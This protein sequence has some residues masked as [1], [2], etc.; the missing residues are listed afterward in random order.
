MLAEY[1]SPEMRARYS[2]A[3]LAG[4][5]WRLLATIECEGGMMFGDGGNVYVSIL[6]DDLRDRRFD[7]AIGS[8]Q[9]A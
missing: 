7:R 9:G 1:A 2:D 4:E 6:E 3:E 5:G 8:A